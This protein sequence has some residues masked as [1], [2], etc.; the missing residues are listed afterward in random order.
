MK[1][2]AVVHSAEDG[3]DWAEVSSVPG[4]VTQGETLEEL[5]ANLH[6]AVEACLAVELDPSSIENNARVVEIA[7]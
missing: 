2:K 3:G 5:L 6:E 1:I 4:C 7:V